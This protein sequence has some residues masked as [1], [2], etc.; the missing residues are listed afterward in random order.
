MKRK[1]LRLGFV[2][3]TALMMFLSNMYSQS[4]PGGMISYWKFQEASGPT[5]SD[6]FGTHDALSAGSAPTQTAGISG[7]GQL[8]S[9]DAS[10]YLAIPGHANFNWSS[11]ASFTVAFWAKYSGTGAIEVFIGRDDPVSS[12]Q[13]WIG[14]TETG[15]IEWFLRSS[16]GTN[17]DVTT[18]ITYNNSLWHFIVAVRDASQNKNFLYVDGAAVSS[19][20]SYSGNFS[21]TADLNIGNLIVDS[22]PPD[23]FVNGSLD[24]IAI[25][26]RA[27]SSAEIIAQFINIKDYQIG[28]CDGDAPVILSS[29][30][31]FATA[32]QAYSYDV[33]ASGNSK[34]TYSLV[35]KPA[36]MT[37]DASTG[38]ITWTPASVSVNGHVTVRATNN[39]GS[40]EQDF[41][42]FIA[43]APNCRNNMIAYWD[44]NKTGSAAYV[45]NVSGYTLTGGS[46]SNTS[47][48]VGGA[49][50]FDGVN[51]SLNLYDNSEPENVFFDFDNVPNFSFELWM[52]SNASSAKPMVMIGRNMQNMLPNPNNTQYWLGVLPD[53]SVE[54][55]LSD[56]VEPT[57]TVG[58]VVTEGLN[59]LDNA[60][61]HIVGTYSAT[62]NNMKLYVDNALI[63]TVNKNFQNFG[64]NS[65]LNIGCLHTP[66]DKFWYAGMLDE[67]VIYSAELTAAQ[68]TSHYNDGL[69]GLGACVYNYAPAILTTPDTTVYEDGSYTYNFVASEINAGDVVTI[70]AVTKPAWMNF[71]YSATDTFAVLSGN[72][73]NANVGYHDVTL[74]V[75]DGSISVDQ[76]FKVHVINVNDP[77]SI[78]S[79]PAA[80]VYEDASYSYTLVASDIDAADVLTYSAPV[81]PAWM[82]FDPSTHVLSGLPTNEAVGVNDITLSVSDGTVNADQV[83]QL[84]VINVNDL[85]VITSEP[86]TTSLDPN[87]S[88]L[89]E[90]T[91]TDVDEGDVLTF[92]SVT[93]PDWLS[94]TPSAS[95]GILMGIPSASDK[96]N[97]SIILKVSDGHGEVLQGFT[98]KVNPPSAIGDVNGNNFSV[99]PN[100]VQDK[101]YFRFSQEV[102]IQVA[103]LD[104]TGNTVKEIAAENTGFLEV[105][106]SDLRSGLY[107]YKATIDGKTSLGKITK[108]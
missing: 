9:K 85:P 58:E 52:K 87:E 80:T 59:V 24:E 3:L 48:K 2:I 74:R 55:Y 104:I 72:P 106:M 71:T 15:T 26:N 92:S 79:T 34:P 40:V 62:S 77:P 45:D 12:M 25:Y 5:Y 64:G 65:N 63:G 94:F 44:F 97:H 76:S 105:N 16:D 7:K 107:L 10:N 38:I 69:A 18:A 83:F 39:K 36:G 32:G 103:I 43:A 50:S 35:V 54:F 96:G 75:S 68:V 100:P 89:Y 30:M 61:H 53:G 60:W 6:A 102:D 70:S 13:W 86:D 8:F 99:F 73:T 23:Y 22:Y 81:L 41:N 1:Y 88:Y 91:A 90:F 46:P 37:I 31:V 27:L 19:T 108:N 95:S 14:R 42:V 56:Y 101:V 78:S 67:V 29:P 49:F 66:D 93:I 33:D 98:L 51:D 84:T 17:G 57:S 47:G 82:S 20:V 28:Y 21:S 4:C 11:S